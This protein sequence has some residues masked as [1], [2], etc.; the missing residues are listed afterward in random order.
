[1]SILAIL[2]VLNFDFKQ[3]WATFKSQ[4]TKNSKFRV[5]EIAKNDILRPFEFTKI[6]FHLKSELR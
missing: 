4:F 1:M 2:K 3:I 5:S 6:W